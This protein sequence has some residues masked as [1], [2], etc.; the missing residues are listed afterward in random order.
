MAR[1]NTNEELWL[2]ISAAGV[3]RDEATPGEGLVDTIVAI[4]QKDVVLGTGE[5]TG[6]A[7]DDWIRVGSGNLMEVAKI[8]SLATDTLTMYSEIA[9]PHA[10]GAPVTSLEKVD[11]GAVSEDGITRDTSVERTE[12]RAATQASPY[13]TLVANVNQR[14]SWNLLNHSNENVLMALGMDEGA[15][16]G[17]GTGSDPYVIDIL[18]DDM[19]SVINHAL[20]F[21]GALKDGTLFEIQGWSCDFDPNQTLNYLRGQAV[22]LPIAADVQHIRYYT[23]AI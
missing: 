15:I 18:A 19:G 20:W 11:L 9:F 12:I 3:Y 22:L 6:F 10:V 8:E 16:H 7:V 23:P 4:A 13:A 2:E 5:G 14:L 1:K 17:T 21:T